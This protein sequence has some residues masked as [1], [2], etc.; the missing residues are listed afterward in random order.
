MGRP[1]GRLAIKESPMAAKS[2]LLRFTVGALAIGWAGS[3]LA[4]DGLSV[5]EAGSTW[6]RWQPR[7]ELSDPAGPRLG[8]TAPDASLPTRAA[9]LGD[10]DLGDFGL[11]LPRTSGRF[12]ATSGL[13]FGLRGTGHNTGGLLPGPGPEALPPSAPYLGVGY[14]GWLLKSG[15]SFTADVGLTA[16]YPGGTWRLGRALLGNQ[17]AETALRELRLQPRLQ[18][19]VQYTY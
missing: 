18:L 13:L 16:D 8:L 19:G 5:P 7:L 14:S 6:P 3:A 9:L 4:I 11:A 2:R 10:Y 1:L 12:R 15:L 17:G